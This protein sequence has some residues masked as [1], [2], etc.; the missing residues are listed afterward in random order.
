MSYF[1]DFGNG[2]SRKIPYDD[3][4]IS[5]NERSARGGSSNRMG[6]SFRMGKF[7]TLIISFMVVLN[8]ILSIVCIY[9]IKNTK[10]R[11]IYNNIIEVG[12]GSEVSSAVKLSA[13]SSSVAVA[14]GSRCSTEYEFYNEMDSRGA[15][16]LS[17][18]CGGFPKDRRTDA[19]YGTG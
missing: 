19:V 13:Y 12:A 14:A 10:N 17:H 15:G 5:R 2:D 3:I 11:T 6:R 18:H 8:L 9:F 16:S 4:P 7:P 1:D